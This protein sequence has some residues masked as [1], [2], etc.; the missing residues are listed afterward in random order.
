MTSQR[1]TAV[2]ATVVAIALA[3]PGCGRQRG[4]VSGRIMVDGVPLDC[5]IVNF[6]APGAAA[7]AAVLDGA[8]EAGGVPLGAVRIAV[9]ALPRPVVAP[10]PQGASRPYAPLPARY[11]SPEESGLT[12]EVR[13]GR[14]QRDITLSGT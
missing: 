3:A 9:R 2:V 14:Q 1:W 4:D 11:A 12:L 6:V 13:P 5:G 7:S 8:Y 10:P